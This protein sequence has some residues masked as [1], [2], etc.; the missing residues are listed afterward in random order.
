MGICPELVYYLPL[1]LYQ[2]RI[3]KRRVGSLSRCI[4]INCGE[5]QIPLF[6]RTAN[7]APTYTVHSTAL[8]SQSLTDAAIVAAFRAE[9]VT[10][11]SFYTK[12][13]SRNRSQLACELY[14]L[15]D[16]R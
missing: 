1:E 8:M 3:H 13:Q 9:Y 10:H 2:A 16:V 11:L 6:V 12:A 15:C 14:N 7:P 5:V 4:Q